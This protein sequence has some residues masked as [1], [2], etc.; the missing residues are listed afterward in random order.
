M[1]DSW[2]HEPPRLET[3]FAELYAQQA[4]KMQ[5]FLLIKLLHTPFM[6]KS[7]TDAKYEYSRV[8]ALAA[9]RAMINAYL[10]LRSYGR[11][12]FV[13]C[14]L[15]DFQAFSAGIVLIINNLLSPGSKAGVADD[16][17][18]DWRLTEALT[19]S[20][21]RTDSLMQCGVASQAATVLSL[22]TQAAA[23]WRPEGPWRRL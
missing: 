22:L 12:T 6:L 1:P 2:W 4:A 3:P 8:S 21:R 20:L 19:T 15:L 11:G 18:E 13:F 23:G 14:E 17:G 10:S 16:G 9:S 7:S 5:Y